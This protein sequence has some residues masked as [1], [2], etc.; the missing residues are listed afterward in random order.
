MHPIENKTFT[1][2]TLRKGRG[3]G[4]LVVKVPIK[5]LVYEMPVP[6]VE[7]NALPTQCKMPGIFQNVRNSMQRR[8]QANQTTSS[9]NLELLL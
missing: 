1:A 7:E 2:W 4:S 9:R 6:S 3:S 5:S 8:Y